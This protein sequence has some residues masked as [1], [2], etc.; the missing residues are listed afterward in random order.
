MLLLYKNA[1]E[2]NLQLYLISKMKNFPTVKVSEQNIT[3]C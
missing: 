2:K 3:P 1:K